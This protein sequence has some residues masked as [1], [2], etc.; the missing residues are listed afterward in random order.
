[1]VHLPRDIVASSF[2]SD[3][4]HSIID[5]QR[6]AAWEEAQRPYRRAMVDAAAAADAYRSS[7]NLAAA[8]CTLRILATAAADEAMT[9]SMSSNQAEYL[10]GW[11]VGALAIAFLKVR[12]ADAATPEQDSAIRSWMG[13]AAAAARGYFQQ[14]RQRGSEDGQNNHLCWAGL[15]AMSAGIATG[16]VE[17]FAW[18]RSAYQ[19]G[20]RRIQADGTLPLEMAR[21]RRA[22]HY[23][24]FAIAPLV[25]MAEL[26]AAN[27]LDL[28]RAEDGA[29]HRLVRRIVDGLRDDRFFVERAG[30]DQDTSAR[31]VVESDHLAWAVPYLRRFPTPELRSLLDQAR[32]RPVLFL[33]G[34]PPP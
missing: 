8:R 25:V 24:L 12:A 23:H 31:E 22:L 14:R 15:T 5:P 20:V 16:D 10:R 3:P 17:L 33:G 6:Y 7:G 11:T 21:G 28:Y 18:G 29:L 34:L 27:G 26:A 13:K 2:Y 9:G 1:V 30:A 19:D 4:K 32:L